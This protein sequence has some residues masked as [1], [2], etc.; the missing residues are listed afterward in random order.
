VVTIYSIAWPTPVSPVS[1]DVEVSASANAP[2]YTF[3][4][5]SYFQVHFVDGAPSER[6][7]RAS[8]ARWRERRSR[9][10]SAH[11]AGST[12]RDLRTEAGF[13]SLSRSGRGQKAD[14]LAGEV[15]AADDGLTGI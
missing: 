6:M 7:G 11:A 9:P 1:S 3:A 4:F 14:R 13:D 15:G 12:S 2:R 5:S 10:G 8:N